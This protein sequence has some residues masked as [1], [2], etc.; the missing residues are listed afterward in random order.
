MERFAAAIL[1]YKVQIL[2]VFGLLFLVSGYFA[3]QVQVNYDLS[4]YLP[5]HTSSTRALEAVKSEFDQALPNLQLMA[6]EIEV[7]DAL[8]LKKRLLDLEEVTAVNWLD[9]LADPAEPPEILDPKLSAVFYKDGDAQFIVTLETSD[10]AGGLDK[11]REAAQIPVSL[12]GPAVDMARA[13]NSVSEEMGRIMLFA[14]PITLVI[15]I[16]STTSYFEPILFLLTIAVGVILNMGTNIFLGEISYITQSVGAVLQLAVSMDYGIFVLHRF[17]HFRHQGDDVETAMKKAIMGAFSAVTSS[18]LTTI[19]GFLALVFMQFRIGPDMGVVLAKGILFSLISVLFFLPALTLVTVKI[20]DKTTH[21]SFLPSEKSFQQVGKWI[22]KASPVILLVVVL[23]AYPLYRA[24]ASNDFLY[25]MGNYPEDSREALERAEILQSFGE[26]R[27]LVLLLPPGESAK[28]A[29]LS[30][31]IRKVPRVK[32]VIS[33]SELVGN[34]IPKEFLDPSQREQFETDRYSR[35]IVTTDLP[36]ESDE[37]FATGLKLRELS[38]EYY[39]E[40]ALWAG[41]PFSLLDMRETVNADNRV[42]NGLAILSVGVVLLFTFRSFSLP[43]IL[44][45]AIEF[46][47]W[48]NLSIPYFSGTPLN[49]IGYLVISTIQLGAT[50]D[51]AILTTEHYL[52]SRSRKNARDAAAEAVGTAMPS[53]ISPALVLAATGFIL[54]ALSTIGIVSEIGL[55]LGRGA[56]FS[57]LTVVLILPALLRFLD[58]LIARTGFG[59][60]RVFHA[61]KET[62]N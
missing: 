3:T 30:T 48:C 53:I 54:A 35:I 42:V 47:I 60:K 7:A 5:E 16:I 15:L 6:K 43:A 61:D 8:L 50:V 1:K 32:S 19:F 17:G 56:L 62:K 46:A 9:D 37:T 41:S 33:Y 2:I 52:D 10:Y 40:E 13:A 44:I 28:E 39:G 12:A 14:V 27:Q 38:E 11:I 21:R 55:V 31:Q 29:E 45:L 36:E 23:A 59:R 51:Y 26:N 22:L 25:G 20:V 57:L 49:Y 24:Q 58:P 4:A 34:Q 18:A